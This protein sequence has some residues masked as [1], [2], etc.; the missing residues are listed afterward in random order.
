MTAPRTEITAAELLAG[1]EA[2]TAPTVLDVRSAHE[3]AS[4]HVPGAIH[5]PFWSLLV[6]SPRVP[7]SPDDE[8]VVYCGHGPRAYLA[9]AALRSRGFRRVTYLQGH[10]TQWASAGLPQERGTS[11]RPNKGL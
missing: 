10:M 4:G 6:Q 8:M 11:R 7:A 2:G 3:F 1:I 9:G 5:I